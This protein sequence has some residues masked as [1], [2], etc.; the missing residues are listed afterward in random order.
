MNKVNSKNLYYETFLAYIWL[1][2][3]R[4]HVSLYLTDCIIYV[5]YDFNRTVLKY[6]LF[7]RHP[8]YYRNVFY[9]FFIQYKNEWK[10]HKF[11]RQKNQ[12]RW[13]L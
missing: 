1:A 2:L 10:E 12:Q 4:D 8:I 5:K 11:W 13:F 9:I 3:K 6:K 7:A